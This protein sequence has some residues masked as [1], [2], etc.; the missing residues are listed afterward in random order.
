MTIVLGKRLAKIL[1]AFVRQEEFAREWRQQH[2]TRAPRPGLCGGEVMCNTS[3]C[4]WRCTPP[5]ACAIADGGTRRARFD[6]RDSL[7]DHASHRP[8]RQM[9]LMDSRQR[10]DGQVA[11]TGGP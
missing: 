2:G 9:L 5:Q 10:R 3:G 7:I 11:R 8:P 1:D 6:R 4:D